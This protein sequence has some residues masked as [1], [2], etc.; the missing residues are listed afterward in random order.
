MKKTLIILACLS[1]GFS[2]VACDN[3]DDAGSQYLK[4]KTI[5]VVSQNLHFDSTPNSGSV[6]IKSETPF[7]VSSTASWVTAQVSGNTISVTVTQNASKN[8]RSAKLI[9]KNQVSDSVNVVVQQD[10][11]VLRPGSYTFNLDD[12]PQTIATKLTTSFDD[13]DISTSS[14]DITAVL[15][16]DS[17]RISVTG[18]DTRKI[19]P[20]QVYLSN[21]AAKDTLTI[22]Q[23]EFS[24]D[25]AGEWQMTYY[26]DMDLKNRKTSTATL[27]D[28]GFML[29]LEEGDF[30]LGSTFSADS[31]TMKF[32]GGTMYPYAGGGY[33]TG[34][35]TFT[36][37]EGDFYYV[38]SPGLQR[39]VYFNYSIN[40]DVKSNLLTGEASD[41]VFLI[42]TEGSWTG[43]S[44][45][46]SD[47]E[48]L[49]GFDD[50]IAGAYFIEFSRQY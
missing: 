30:M 13:V 1:L 15:D 44:F 38:N 22:V 14:D 6:E 29:H 21:G 41:V 43:V 19:R 39:L 28:K 26:D 18:N 33:Y 50:L 31:L 37:E 16:G 27:S 35:F 48:S 20:S 46:R 10:G 42:W 12:N 17:L 45:Y 9:V 7:T 34:V 2:F 4:E 8:G 47:T 24:K 23:S 25:I 36:G 11:F 3:G 49:K 32:E 40:Y 5:S